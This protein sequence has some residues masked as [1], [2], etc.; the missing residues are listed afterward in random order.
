MGENEYVSSPPEFE[1]HDPLPRPD[2][3][4]RETC[5][6]ATY[7]S[8]LAAGRL[9]EPTCPVH[10]AH[11]EGP[12]PF[13]DKCGYHTENCICEVTGEGQPLKGEPLLRVVNG[14]DVTRGTIE[15]ANCPGCGF[16]FD[17]EH[18]DANGDG[19]SCPNC[20]ES[21]PPEVDA[22]ELSKN[23]SPRAAW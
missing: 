22:L 13:C 9:V 2:A 23:T 19:F 3:A 16:R 7:N 8:G 11:T 6:C 15:I 18:T 10:G 21:R 4:P 20:P 14:W 1:G 17:A 12:S 5:I